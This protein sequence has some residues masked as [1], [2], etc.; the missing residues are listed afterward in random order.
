[1]NL[2][3]AKLQAT[4]SCGCISHEG[5]FQRARG[6]PTL[7]GRLQVSRSS[8]NPAWNTDLP[9]HRAGIKPRSRVFPADPFSSNSITLGQIL[10]L[11]PPA[12][13]L[14]FRELPQY[15]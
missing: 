14:G 3:I 12:Q 2:K 9:L 4:V 5:G 8:T 10:L 1:M 13:D 11:N 15:Y 7:T 6:S